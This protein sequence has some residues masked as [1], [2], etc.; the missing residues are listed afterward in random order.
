M[1]SQTPEVPDVHVLER[2][3]KDV[4]QADNLQGWSVA[5]L[6]RARGVSREGVRGKT[7]VLVSEML[8]QLQLA[9]GTFRKDRSAEWLHD[10][11]DG[12]RLASQLVPRRAIGVTL[13]S[14]V[15]YLSRAAR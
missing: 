15:G 5:L 1:C 4:A 7:H 9:V 8:K 13:R 11:L 12:D 2:R 10:L 14:A 6:A 3:D